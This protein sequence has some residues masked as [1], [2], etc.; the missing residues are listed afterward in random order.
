VLGV[1]EE[2]TAEMQAVR[3]LLSQDD[4][5]PSRRT[6]ERRLTGIAEHLPATIWYLG[7][8][9]VEV[10]HPWKQH[11]QAVAIDSTTLEARSEVWHRRQRER[12]E[13][14]CKTIEMQAYWTKSGWHALV[15][16]WK[17][18]LATTVGPVGP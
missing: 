10:M 3:A 5:F 9:L 7:R 14:P 13:V 8:W 12:G 4:G 2:P 18:H 15:Y 17:L 1:L 6:W 11:G 16:G